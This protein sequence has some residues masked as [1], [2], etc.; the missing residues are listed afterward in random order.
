V[1]SML[2]RSWL[3]ESFASLSV[4]QLRGSAVRA[5]EISLALLSFRGMVP[6]VARTPMKKLLLLVAAVATAACAEEAPTKGQQRSFRR[7]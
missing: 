5:G 3:L 4:I 1:T 6:A 7:A 2:R